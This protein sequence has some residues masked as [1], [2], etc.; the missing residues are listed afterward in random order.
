MNILRKDLFEEVVGLVNDL[1]GNFDLLYKFHKTLEYKDVCENLSQFQLVL[2][3]I[4]SVKDLLEFENQ[5]LLNETM[6]LSQGFLELTSYGKENLSKEFG[7]LKKRIDDWTKSINTHCR[8]KIESLSV[9]PYIKTDRILIGMLTG[10]PET[11][12]LNEAC[13]YVASYENVDFFYFTP[14]DINLENKLIL[15]RFYCNGKCV[16]KETAYPDVIYDRLRLRGHE[17]A[18]EIYNT[19]EGIPFTNERYGNS[20]SKLE[21]YD[22]LRNIGDFNPHII[23]YGRVD[24]LETITKYLDEYK[25]IILKPEIGS[26]GKQVFFVTEL[27][28]GDFFVVER[29]KNLRL[30]K[31]E[32]VKFFLSCVS[33]GDF[34][35]QRYI[36]TRTLE[37][38]PFD[39]RIHLMK[40]GND[41]WSIVMIYPRIGIHFGVISATGEGGYI[42]GW[43]GFFERNFPD[44]SFEKTDFSIRK[45]AVDLCTSFEKLQDER[46]N[47]IALDIAIDRDLNLFLIELNANMPGMIYYEFDVARHVIPYC[48][49]L[50]KSTFK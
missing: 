38:K 2:E 41:T 9:Q 31:K 48:A 6:E 3:Y 49:Y 17:T 27:D 16:S 29:A 25:M 46:V 11:T 32:A 22:K 30:G 44:F 4:L 18:A 33:N 21:V 37:N 13:A 42:G 12:R 5:S 40:D 45:L 34:I 20:I 15:G 8:E 39:I 1:V 24:S 19:F 26:F 50:A 36:M 35:V 28:D 23:P 7:T 43:Q 10:A 47:E 14:R